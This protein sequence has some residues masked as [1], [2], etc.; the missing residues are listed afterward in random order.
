MADVNGMPQLPLRV[1]GSPQQRWIA[2]TKFRR[3]GKALWTPATM[4]RLSQEAK[5]G[6]EVAVAMLKR[7][8]TGT[9]SAETPPPG[10][11]S[12]IAASCTRRN[13]SSTLHSCFTW[14][15]PKG[16][17]PYPTRPTHTV[18]AL[19]LRDALVQL[20]GDSV[21]ASSS[22][23]RQHR[24]DGDTWTASTQPSVH[25]LSVSLEVRHHGPHSGSGCHAY[26]RLCERVCSVS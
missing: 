24:H 6:T 4:L 12:G 9:H 18:A 15:Q 8:Y 22:S 1:H 14:H 2:E 23:P 5:A 10:H 7:P 13:A 26:A 3:K 25:Y 21:N 11:S 20:W 19:S 16:D 17:D